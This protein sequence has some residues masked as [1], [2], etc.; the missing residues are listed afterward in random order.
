MRHGH[1]LIS[2]E[3]ILLLLSDMFILR[4]VTMIWHPPMQ[5][6]FVEMFQLATWLCIPKIASLLPMP[7][8]STLKL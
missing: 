2:F 3:H 7:G 1:L 5:N 4:T 8:G 6:I